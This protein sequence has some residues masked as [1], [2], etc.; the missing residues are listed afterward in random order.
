MS[1]HIAW[2][3]KARTQKGISVYT[4]AKLS[5]VLASSIQIAEERGEHTLY[6]SE[7]LA[8]RN[9]LNQPTVQK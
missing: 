1:N 9:V 4:L 2:L 5:G 6:E 8:L 7:R 3:Q